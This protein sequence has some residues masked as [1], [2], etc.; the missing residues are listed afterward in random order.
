[1]KR[2]LAL[3][4]AVVLVATVAVGIVLLGMPKQPPVTQPTQPVVIKIQGSD[5][6]VHFV[7]ALAEAY[8]KQNPGV[9]IEVAGGGSGTGIAALTGGEIDVAD[10]SR[11]IKPK[12]IEEIKKRYGR[13]PAALI[14]GRDM[15]AVVVNPK[16][17]IDKLT[18]EQLAKIYAGEITNWKEVGGPD[19]PIT[20]Y[21][22]Q[23]VSGTYVFFEEHVVQKYAKKSYSPEMRQLIGNVQIHDA[24]VEDE[25]GIGYIGLGYITDKVKALHL[26]VD[27][28]T[29]FSPLD[30]EAVQAGKYPLSRPLF[31]YMIAPPM[32]CSPLYHFLRFEVSEEGQKIVEKEGF[33]PILEVDKKH[34]EDFWK[35]TEL[36]S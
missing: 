2:N 33:H 14:V 28:K 29:Y 10:A 11:P 4:L 31:Q 34:N 16:N 8:T 3:G 7:A 27:G 15:L 25:T 36:E 22:R 32:K 12:E 20:L 23:S 6:M 19:M 13:E 5:T 30:R 18:L 9:K 24:V 1:M 17:P 35:L 21:G 26:S